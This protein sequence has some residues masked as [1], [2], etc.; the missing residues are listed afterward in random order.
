MQALTPQA[1]S[2]VA[3]FTTL[4]SLL[5]IISLYGIRVLVVLQV[6]PATTA[7]MIPGMVR[8]GIVCLLTAFIACGQDPA[9]LEALNTPQMLMLV[10]KEAFIGL[11]IGYVA[12]SF[13]WIAQSVGTLIDDLAGFNNVQMQNPQA[14]LQNTPVGTLLLQLT[15]TLF[16]ASGGLIVLLGVLFQS[17]RWWPLLAFVPDLH[18]AAADLLIREGDDILAAATKMCAP[19]MLALV[20]VD[21]GLGIVSRAASKLE[22]TSL[23]QPLKGALALLVLIAITATVANQVRELLHLS[24]LQSALSGFI[25]HAPPR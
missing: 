16:Y 21:V 17:Y 25:A 10:C 13:F 3:L 18:T 20:L 6:L 8:S 14:G 24:N 11:V 5:F 7:P 4:H 1:D 2:L 23:A 19:V 22:P 9:P 12:S 15:V